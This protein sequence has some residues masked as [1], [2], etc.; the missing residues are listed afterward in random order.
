MK[1]TRPRRARA[2][3]CALSIKTKQVAGVTVIVGLASILLSGWYLSS[4][5]RVCS[6]RRDARAIHRDGDLPARPSTSSLP[7]APAAISIAEPAERR[8]AASMLAGER[9]LRQRAVRGDRR[10]AGRDHRAQRSTVDRAT[11]AAGGRRLRR[12]CSSRARRAGAGDLHAG[13]P[14]RIEYRRAAAPRHDRVRIDS[15]RRLDAAH[16][17]RQF[18]EGAHARRSSRP[19]A[20]VLV[21]ATLVAMLLRRSC[22]GR[23]TSSAAAWRAWA[24]ASWT[25]TWTCRKD[26]SS[27]TSATRSRR[28]ARGSPPTARELAGQRA[29]LESVV[30]H[31]EDAV[32]LFA[33]DGT[34]LFANPAMRASLDGAG[35]DAQ[36][37]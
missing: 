12:R 4:L 35:T 23:S 14:D 22:C 33:P 26:A 13:G 24:A 29:T 9:V 3:P 1:E 21:G 7:A 17:R 37:R 36:R 31:L 10:P 11:R 32:A 19:L 2:D 30:E 20:L 18:N 27:A 16:R 25:S 15:R 5:A 34:L 28:S 8:R 6:R